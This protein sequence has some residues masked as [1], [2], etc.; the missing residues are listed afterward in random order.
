MQSIADITKDEILVI[1]GNVDCIYCDF[2]YL[3]KSPTRVFLI[4]VN[5]METCNFPSLLSD[6]TPVLIYARNIPKG[7][8]SPYADIGYKRPSFQNCSTHDHHQLSLID[9]VIESYV[10]RFAQQHSNLI[11]MGPQVEMVDGI[12]VFKLGFTV[13]AKGFIPAGE[14]FF[15]K[16]LDGIPTKVVSGKVDFAKGHYMFRP[17]DGIV[18]PGA[19]I[20]SYAHGVPDT[21]SEV[22]SMCT[23]GMFVVVTEVEQG[24]P[25]VI[26]R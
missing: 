22:K 3:S 13:Y 9:H 6:K 18:R 7:S 19:A 1:K 10:E 16:T 21:L 17:M 26:K 11:A 23:L 12:R 14:P 2:V 8:T 20:S 25:D 24:Q 15:P 4:V 5:G